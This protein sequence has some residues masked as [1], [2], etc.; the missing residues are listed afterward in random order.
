M[1]PDMELLGETNSK[2]SLRK[3]LLA[4]GHEKF[5]EGMTYPLNSKR[6]ISGQLQVLAKIIWLPE[7]CQC[8]RQDMKPKIL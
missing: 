3:F 8:S 4:I 2:A 1:E 6:L 5:P 7:D